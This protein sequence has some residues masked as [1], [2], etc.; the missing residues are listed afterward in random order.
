MA[1]GEG[2]RATLVVDRPSSAGG[3]GLERV[4]EIPR[5]IREAVPIEIRSTVS[6]GA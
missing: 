5:S 4:A 1:L 3:G 2:G 6:P